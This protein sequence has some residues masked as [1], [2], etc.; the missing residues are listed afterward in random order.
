LPEQENRESAM[1]TFTVI[2]AVFVT[3]IVASLC[4]GDGRASY[5]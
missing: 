2:G 5:E 3:L 4:S 1:L